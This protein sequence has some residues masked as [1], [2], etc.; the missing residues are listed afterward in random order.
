MKEVR[1]TKLVEQT[2]ITWFSDDGKK[3]D[4]EWECKDYERRLKGEPTEKAYKRLVIA[5][6]EFP[7]QN[8]SGECFVDLVKLK[9]YDDYRTVMDYLEIVLRCDEIECKEPENYP[10]LKVIVSDEY[11]AAFAYEN[12]ITEML[13]QCEK[14]M[15]IVEKAISEINQ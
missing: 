8:W 4:S 5:E 7:F 1:E 3:F 9:S 12:G 13:E 11:Y 10:C 15:T 14:M 2:T 6:L